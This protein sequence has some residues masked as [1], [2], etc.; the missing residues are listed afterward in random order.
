MKNQLLTAIQKLSLIGI[1][2]LL[3]SCGPEETY[4]KPVIETT[5]VS[6][7]TESTVESGG[8]ISSDEGSLVTERGLCWSS[9]PNPTIKDNKTVNAAGTGVF[10]S[11]ITGLT[12]STTYY[13]RA[14]ATNKGG[15][16]YGLQVTFTTK[17][18]SLTSVPAY[19]IMATTAMSGGHVASD[20]DSITI[21]AR[22]VCWNTFPNPTIQDSTTV[23]GFGK[24]PFNSMMSHLKPQTTYF[25]RAY[26]TNSVETYYGNEIS[27]T[28]QD[29]IAELTTSTASS[30]KTSTATIG[31]NV[32]DEGGD[33]VVSRGICWSTSQNPTIE[34]NVA[35]STATSGYYTCYLNGL[36]ANTSY[37]ARAFA[38]NSIGTFYGNE[39]SFTT[40]NGLI[41]LITSNATSISSSSFI[42]GGNIISDGGAT[43][44]ER[45]VC[46]SAIQN[47]TVL[48]FKKADGTGIGSFTA[49]ITSLTPLTTY[50]VRSYAVN[51]TGTYYGDQIA[52]TTSDEDPTKVTDIEG[53]EYATVKIG[54]QL[55]MASNLKTTKY[56][57]GDPIVNMTDYTVWVTLTSGAYCDYDN[58]TA[59]G[60]VYGHLYNWYAVSDSRNI[61]PA[62]W[63]VPSDAEW[64]VLVTYLGGSSVA[65]GKM[66]ET[67]TN[68]WWSP[69][70]G[71]T[72][73]SGF[74]GLPGGGSN[75]RGWNINIY[76]FWWSSTEFNSTQAW[77]RYLYKDDTNIARTFNNTKTTGYSIRCIKD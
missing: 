6:N 65:G 14:Y 57:N 44:T 38:S 20:G 69:N 9:N 30:I 36:T 70:Y 25:I 72:N 7:V 59:N 43:I 27:F 34:N 66:K 24:G 2:G 60:T 61:A 74:T 22:G 68:H 37:Y 32:T 67:G 55:W 54:N 50:Y 76:G 52:V 3:L 73:E 62:G 4:L 56:R 49:S 11:K 40:Q 18:L 51:N 39:T 13:I 46:W 5:D 48:D 35:T 71:A 17:T 53:N 28:T 33:P 29:G 41:N 1:F 15:T 10:V 47:P 8:M 45:G 16:S 23:N 64:D 75:T 26:V 21:K 77:Y 58:L 31:G 63:H 12:P 19:F 42:S